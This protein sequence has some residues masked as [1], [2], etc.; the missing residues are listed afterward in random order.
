MVIVTMIGR[1]RGAFHDEIGV[2]TFGLKGVISDKQYIGSI[3]TYVVRRD[4]LQFCSVRACGS[5]QRLENEFQGTN[6]GF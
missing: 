3:T 6:N 2:R 5:F 1:W 4:V